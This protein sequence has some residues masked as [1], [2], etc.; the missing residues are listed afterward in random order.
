MWYIYRVGY[1][2]AIKWWNVAICDNTDGSSVYHAKWNKPEGKGQ[3]QILLLMCGIENKK[4]Q[5]NKTNRL[6]NIDNNM[7]VTRGKEGWE[8]CEEWKKA[9][10]KQSISTERIHTFRSFTVMHTPM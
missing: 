3:E 10:L 9:K 8:Q 7:M 6:L 1:Y 4:Q 5:T 2:L